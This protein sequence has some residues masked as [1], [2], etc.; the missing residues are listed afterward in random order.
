MC[1]FSFSFCFFYIHISSSQPLVFF[2]FNM[3]NNRSCGTMIHR[4]TC[5]HISIAK[6]K[7]FHNEVFSHID[8]LFFNKF[9]SIKCF[10][11]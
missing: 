10:I 4:N 9:H 1:Y 7:I 8:Y 11:R 5:F 3:K 2:R 6:V